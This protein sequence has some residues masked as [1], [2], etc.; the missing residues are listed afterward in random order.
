M[1]R[2]LKGVSYIVLFLIVLC[3]LAIYLLTPS[4]KANIDSSGNDTR[5]TVS[6]KDIVKRSGVGD[7]EIL[8]DPPRLEGTV[9]VGDQDLKNIVYTVFLNSGVD[10]LKNHE[11]SIVDDHVLVK[12]PYRLFDFFNTQIDFEL[13]PEIKDQNLVFVINKIHV[14][15]IP[16]SESMVKKLVESKYPDKNIDIQGNQVILDKS[17]IEPAKLNDIEVKNGQ[18][19]IDLEIEADNVLRALLP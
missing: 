1:S 7:M 4:E 16:I 19:N 18:L 14:G 8:R 17:Y 15:K 9:K 3:G 10:Q 2:F 11:V 12:L 6:I 5:E 13:E